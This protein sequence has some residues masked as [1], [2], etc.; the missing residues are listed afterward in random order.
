MKIKIQLFYF[1]LLLFI[2][3]IEPVYTQVDNWTHF[4][5]GNLDGISKS[6]NVPVTFND[7]T[8]VIWMTEIFGRGWSSPVVY[9]DQI[10]LTTS[11]KIFEIPGKLKSIREKPHYQD[12]LIGCANCNTS[13]PVISFSHRMISLSITLRNSRILPVQFIF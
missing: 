10:W 1:L 4:R 2:L 13:F 11:M 9:G 8:N 12:K 6:E 3:N 7:T 5:G